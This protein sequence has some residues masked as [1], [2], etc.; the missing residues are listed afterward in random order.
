MPYSRWECFDVVGGTKNREIHNCPTQ[1]ISIA[2][3]DHKH[4]ETRLLVGILKTARRLFDHQRL[5][6]MKMFENMS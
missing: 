5:S 4:L 3:F 6:I 1:T 2:K